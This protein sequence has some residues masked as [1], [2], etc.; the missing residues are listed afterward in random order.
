VTDPFKKRRLGHISA[1]DVSTVRDSSK[2]NV[3]VVRTMRT[4]AQWTFRT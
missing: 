4:T 1:Y 3:P 2:N